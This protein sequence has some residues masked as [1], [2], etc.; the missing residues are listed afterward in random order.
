MDKLLSSLQ[1]KLDLIVLDNQI[2]F[3]VLQDIIECTIL[4][5][6][7]TASLV[8]LILS[9]LKD[10]NPFETNSITG[11]HGTHDTDYKHILDLLYKTYQ[12]PD[13]RSS[14]RLSTVTTT[15]SA[16][17]LRKAGVDKW[18][19]DIKFNSSPGNTTL[20]MPAMHIE[21]STA[22]VL[23]NLSAYERCFPE[24]GNY[25][26]SYAF[27]MM[28]LVKTK[29]DLLEL[30]ESKVI[31][32]PRPSVR[33]FDVDTIHELCKGV[34][35]KEFLFAV[36]GMDS[37]LMYLEN[38]IEKE[39]SKEIRK[40][41]DS[42]RNKHRRNQHSQSICEV[43]DDIRSPNFHK[44]IRIGILNKSLDGVKIRYMFDLFESLESPL[45]DIRKE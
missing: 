2:P 42:H 40:F 13:A 8:E 16:V 7:P 10:V 1:T 20:T 12:P 14:D 5:L 22:P 26:A 3:F 25:I 4:K 45:D 41:L 23:W 30:V 27:A 21:Y 29:E 35:P 31:R 37:K 32:I 9:F 17:K 11:H 38:V 19:M 18:K 6:D 15:Y 43:P 24:V 33:Q 28:V 44:T 34:V 36:E 39:I